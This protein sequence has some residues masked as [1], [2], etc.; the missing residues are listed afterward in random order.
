[1]SSQDILDYRDTRP[2]EGGPS[3]SLANRLVRVAWMLTWKLLASWTPTPLHRYRVAIIRLFGGKIHW[4]AHVYGSAQIWK[5]SNLQMD[6]HSCLGPR[7]RCYC[8]GTITLGEGAIVSQDASLC[9]GSH[10]IYDPHFQL[11]AKPIRIEKKAW[12]AAEAF[13]GPGAVIGQEAVIGARAV[14]FGHAKPGGIYLGNPATLTKER[15]T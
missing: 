4:T 9:S 2:T 6:A 10:D 11:I 7:V 12:I 1:M 3:Y 14:L 13:I 15:G 5:P 8:M